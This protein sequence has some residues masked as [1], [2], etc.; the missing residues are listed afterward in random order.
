MS[1]KAFSKATI[2]LIPREITAQ[3]VKVNLLQELSTLEIEF[4]VN[5]KINI[6]SLLIDHSKTLQFCIGQKFN[7]LRLT[8]YCYSNYSSHHHED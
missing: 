2:E 1:V 8:K 7:Y 5:V 6:F 4:E 3:K